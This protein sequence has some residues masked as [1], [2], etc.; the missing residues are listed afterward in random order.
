VSDSLPDPGAPSTTD[1]FTAQLRA[2]RRWAGQPS[3]RRLRQLGG[4]RRAANGGN[5]I[6]RLPESTLSYVLRGDRPAGAE[7][8]RSFV[9]ACLRARHRDPEE[10]AAQVERWHEAWLVAAGR[11][12]SALA[13]PASSQP[14]APVPRQ[15][16]ADIAGFTGRATELAALAALSSGS[17][18]TVPV[19][20]A[21]T[22]LAGVGKT[23]LAVRAAHR[24]AARYP[25][26][27]LFIDLR[28]FTTATSR[29][30]PGDALDRL[31]RLL[32]VPGQRIP[33]DPD[34]RAALWRST[35]AGRRMLIVLDNSADEA[36]L[37]PL[38]PG[39]AGCLVLVTSRSRLTGPQ[40][41]HPMALD[42]LPAAEAAELFVLAAGDAAGDAAGRAPDLLA[43][44][45]ELCGRLPLAIQVAAARLR[46]HPTWGV[47]ELVARLRDQRERLRELTDDA[48]PRSVAAALELSYRQLPADERRLYRRLGQHPGP[49]IDRYAAAAL[50]G[51]TLEVAGRLLDQLL[52]SHL[53]QEPAPGRYVCHD[54]VRAHAT[55]TA[56][57][58]AIPGWTGQVRQWRCRRRQHAALVRLRDYYRHTASV[59]MDTA[60]PFESDR[61]PQVPPARTPAPGLA[62]PAAATGWLDLELPNLLAVARLT[63][64]GGR[65]AHTW[66]LSGLLHRHLRTRGQ[67]H[68]AEALHR[69]ALT[70]ARAA[71]RRAEE[72]R[73]MVSLGWI[74]G[75]QCRYEQSLQDFTQARDIARATGDRGGELQ[76]LAGLGEVHRQQ[77][78]YD[79]ALGVLD[80]ALELARAAGDQNSLLD[81]LR[82]QGHVHLMQ[83]RY[84]PAADNLRRALEVA[85][86]IGNRAGEL[87]ALVGVCRV[88]LLRDEHQPALEGF[89]QALEI[90]RAI[91]LPGGEINVL[92]GIAEVYLTRGQHDEALAR[93]TQ[94]L[95]LARATGNSNAEV[96]TLNG[97]SGVLRAQ[98]RYAQAARQYQTLLALALDSGDRNAQY[99]ARQGLGRVQH[100]TGHP[101]E[102]V[103]HHQQALAL[104]TLLGQPADQ[105]RAH[106]GLARAHRAL[107]QPD[108]ARRHWQCA[109]D[110]LA[111]LGTDR[112]EDAEASAASIRAGLA[113]LDPHPRAPEARV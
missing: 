51:S 76:A 104:A 113:E 109:I 35:L 52:H 20:S 54:L 105:V 71:G 11:A 60:Y 77:G 16:P 57:T 29:V 111:N 99:E 42:T 40:V 7:F 30:D 61:R 45:V 10:V 103:Q 89:G 53:V 97:I 73:A 37:V 102:A 58:G 106:D 108:L 84:E 47:A 65:P 87:N 39:T 67:Y 75:Y 94:A 4:T 81:A 31:L 50:L 25:D 101:D 93:Y 100:A 96:N 79:E 83:G 80:R 22:G 41:T 62:E 1:E 88:H 110:L 86:R 46:N 48:G 68:A 72:L 74:R 107:R 8:V 32:G 82:C 5:K 63:I 26:G 9:A 64:G 27:Q 38:L 44:A 55:Q 34:D 2:L 91:G 36:Q 28:G 3:L 33:A 14:I 43:E 12:T 17:D 98:G 49:D 92:R 70:S 78:R 59:A 15:L 112:T 19:V 6:D 23:A 24:L 18:P 85:R 66:Q 90:A 69:L 95:E 13:G 21:I 56:T